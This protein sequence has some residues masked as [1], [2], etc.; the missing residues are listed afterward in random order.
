MCRG[1]L[2]GTGLTN[3]EEGPLQGCAEQ[4]PEAWVWNRRERPVAVI[5]PGRGKAQPAVGGQRVVCGGRAAD[6]SGF[7]LGGLGWNLE[8]CRAFGGEAVLREDP[9][10]ST[11]W[12][13]EMG[14]SVLGM[15]G[16]LL[17]PGPS[18]GPPALLEA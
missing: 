3:G 12:A 11:V 13:L 10:L 15:G 9:R 5:C 7:G 2:F 1:P 16:A 14:V 17:S 6:R 8:V 18:V 4:G